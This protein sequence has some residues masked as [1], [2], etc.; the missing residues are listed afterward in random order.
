M[1]FLLKI[2]KKKWH[3]RRI[4]IAGYVKAKVSNE[5][6]D[7]KAGDLL[8]IADESGYARKAKAGDLII[9]RARE[10][11]SFATTSL[12]FTVSSTIEVVIGNV[13]G[14][15]AQNSNINLNQDI[16]ITQS[17]IIS[18][19]ASLNVSD[20]LN[21]FRELGVIIEKGIVRIETLVADIFKVKKNNSDLVKNTIGRVMVNPGQQFIDVDNV[22]VEFSSEIFISPNKPVLAAI[23][24]K[25]Q[26]TGFRICL[27]KPA[28]EETI[29]SWWIIGVD[30]IGNSSAPVSS[31]E[32]NQQPEEIFSVIEPSSPAESV[33]STESIEEV[34][35][36]Q[37]EPVDKTPSVEEGADLNSSTST[38]T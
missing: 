32:G 26:S 28:T 21:F 8:A 10:N 14:Y 31:G 30:E 36:A 2:L 16:S 22:R 23:C 20:V 38:S 5:N 9:A 19:T 29:I 34:P 3:A 27:E 12:Q 7:I 35:Q 11:A 33:S 1:A 4:A 15:L 25:K 37:E 17:P 13:G 18:P 24:D 6:G